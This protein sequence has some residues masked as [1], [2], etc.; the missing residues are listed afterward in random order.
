MNKQVL[1]VISA[2]SGEKDIDQDFIFEA[3]E[4]ALAMATKKHLG[5]EADI[6]VEIDRENGNYQT[7]RRWTIVP[8]EEFELPEQQLTPEQAKIRNPK[9]QMGEVIE[10][11]IESVEFSRIGAHVA[12]QVI[13]Q[14]VRGAERNKVAQMYQKRVGE[15]ISG[16]VKKIIRDGIIM[17]IGSNLEAI[18]PREFAVIFLMC[19]HRHEAHKFLLAVQNQ[20]FS[21][22]FLKLKY[23]KLAKN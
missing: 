3:I 11:A 8:E 10:E 9:A 22:N 20:N 17:D 16:T 21:L 7:F 14:K 12:K 2:V 19:A 6:R 15:L 13:V 5:V 1:Q 4:A 18:I 23:R